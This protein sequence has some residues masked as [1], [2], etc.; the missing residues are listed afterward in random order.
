MADNSNFVQ[1]EEHLGL[2]EVM[3]FIVII[4]LHTKTNFI[5]CNKRIRSVFFVEQLTVV[6][7]AAQFNST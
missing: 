3:Y 4:N 6:P 1:P 2:I 7:S 5:F